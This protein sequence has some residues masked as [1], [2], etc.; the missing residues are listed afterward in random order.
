MNELTMQ[1]NFL[2]LNFTEIGF[3]QCNIHKQSI[4]KWLVRILSIDT[5]V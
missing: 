3:L 1:Q 2:E 5:Q 4:E